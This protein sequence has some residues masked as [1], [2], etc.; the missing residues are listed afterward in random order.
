MPGVDLFAIPTSPEVWPE[1]LKW[2]PPL[3]E[4]NS[5]LI[6]NY[7]FTFKMAR[8][9]LHLTTLSTGAKAFFLP[10]TVVHSDQM[11]RFCT[12]LNPISGVSVFI[13][14]LSIR[15]NSSVVAYYICVYLYSNVSAHSH[16]S[17]THPQ[18]FTYELR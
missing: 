6:E 5:L 18:Y 2:K 16:E 4:H 8:Y 9:R 17:I 3:P 10:G 7:S 1:W 15:S 14:L 11:N 13:L 12:N